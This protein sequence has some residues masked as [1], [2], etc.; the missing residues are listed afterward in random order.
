MFKKV[1]YDD[2]VNNRIFDTHVHKRIVAVLPAHNEEKSI[3]ETLK[4]VANLY[5]PEGVKLDVFIANDR[6]TDGTEAEIRKWEDKLNLFVID[7]VDNK[8]RKVGA[9]N[10]IYRLFFGDMS[11]TA[12]PLAKQHIQ[13]VNNIVAFLGLDA[14]IYLDKD[15][16]NTMY[17]EMNS[18]YKIGAV[19]ANYTCLLPE[20]KKHILKSSPEAES[21]LPEDYGPIARFMTMLQSKDFA[22]WTIRQKIDGYKA[23]INGGQASL[24]RPKALREVYDEFKLNGIYSN[25]TDTEDLRLSQDLR[26]LNWKTMISKSARCYVDSMKNYKSLLNQRKKWTAGK[27]QFMLSSASHE[28]L[29]MWFQ[30]FL[31]LMNFIIRVM[32]VIL[33]PTAIVVGMFTWNWLWIM[34]W[35][36]SG[37]LNFITVLKTPLHRFT[38]LFWAIIGVSSELWMWFEM[39]VHIS[40]WLD[41]FKMNKKDGWALQEQAENGTLK[42]NFTGVLAFLVIILSVAGLYMSGLVSVASTIALVKPYITSGFNLL[43]GLTL[44]TIVLMLREVWKMR[45]NQK[46]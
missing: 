30:E 5:I 8:E 31:L 44:F 10:S 17:Q 11:E 1:S 23:E 35:V 29:K 33:V 36:I 45:G 2:A 7:T 38:D 46:A 43:T 13:S 27:V 20:S 34:P 3:G 12:E 28:S 41:Q 37:V 15:A 32:L 25:E 14:D 16:L 40:V 42:N 9:L 39:R 6:S 24:F 22:A 26:K 18:N 4:S 19:S 21:Q